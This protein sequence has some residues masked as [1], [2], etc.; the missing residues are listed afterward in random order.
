MPGQMANE[1]FPLTTC[2]LILPIR[3]YSQGVPFPLGHSPGQRALCLHV[4]SDQDSAR[5]GTVLPF[6]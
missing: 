3:V 2:A 1:S 5:L 4:F 6:A